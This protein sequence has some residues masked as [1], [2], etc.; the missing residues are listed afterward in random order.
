MN[1]RVF[2]ATGTAAVLTPAIFLEGCNTTTVADFVNLIA[3]D[4]ATLATY[5]GDTSLAAQIKADAAQIVIDITNWQSGSAATD[6]INAINDLIGLINA[7]P[8]AIPYE[9]L[10]VLIL[11]ALTGLLAL[12]PSSVAAMKPATRAAIN[13]HNVTPTHYNGFDKKSMTTGK[14]NFVASWT[15]LSANVPL[16]H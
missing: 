9:P 15:S 6:A 14:N 16:Q 13:T 12:L 5:F 8:I 11:S 4:A 1:R 2:L 7:I 3:T 10:I